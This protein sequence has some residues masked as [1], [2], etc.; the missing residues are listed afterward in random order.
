MPT[1]ARSLLPATLIAVLVAVTPARAAV[2]YTVNTSADHASSVSEC[3]GAPGDC[4]LR[5]ALDKAGN[6]DTVVV[7]ASATPYTVTDGVIAVAGGV[8]IQG[9]G[10]AATT[11]SGG[12]T[13]QLLSVGSGGPITIES[14]TLAGGTTHSPFV[15]SGSIQESDTPDLTLDGVTIRDGL[16]DQGYGGAMEIGGSVTIRNSR[17]THDMASGGGLGGAIDVLGGGTMTISNSVFE[18]NSYAGGPGGAI[19]VES[20]GTLTVT[21]TTFSGNSAGG[22]SG[23]AVG[24]GPG[25]QGTFQN[26]TFGG[27]SA[28]TSGGAIEFDGTSLSLV[29]DTFFGNSSALGASLNNASGTTTAQNTIFAAPLGATS[30]AAPV[31]TSGHDLD[32]SGANSCGLSAGSGDLIGQSP[33]LGALADN[34]SQVP[35]AGGP[36]RTMAIGS[37]SPAIGHADAA[38]CAAVAD[39]DERG[40]PRPGILGSG[41]DIGAFET[42]QAGSSITAAASASKLTRGQSVTLTAT[43]APDRTLPAAVPAPA[44]VAIFSDG[45]AVLGNVPVSGGRATLTTSALAVGNHSITVSYTGDSI[46]GAS[47][48]AALSLAVAAG[49]PRISGL[50]QSHKVWRLGSRR[51]RLSKGRKVPTGTTF[52][53]KLAAPASLRLKFRRCVN[54]RRGGRHCKPTVA[55]GAL[56]FNNVRA[57]QHKLS[58]QGR[59]KGRRKLRPGRYTL[60]ITASNSTGRVSRSIKFT[61]VR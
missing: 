23:G 51:A 10:A 47:N 12:G 39:V 50:R 28:P 16:T 55:V 8:T 21:S 18:N 33:A 3:S 30:C 4:S 36:P 25:T 57:G 43:V 44:G 42:L 58:F 41:C 11:I 49:P 60:T 34:S 52:G 2:T 1:L 38:G 6:G 40:F 61:I 22:A 14:L 29:N 13:S 15:Q 19:Y 7:P 31:T 5:Q 26:T 27:N 35:T 45:P 56:A 17:F 48:A 37:G 32:D 59:L 54:A 20:G 9:A 53:F 46:Y 24:F